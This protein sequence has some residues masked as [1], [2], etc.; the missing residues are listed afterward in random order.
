M[1]RLRVIKELTWNLEDDKWAK[2][3]KPRDLR[4]VMIRL[5]KT[6]SQLCEEEELTMKA[7]AEIA[8]TMM[9]MELATESKLII[10]AARPIRMNRDLK[11]ATEPQNQCCLV[12]IRCAIC[13]YRQSPKDGLTKPI[14]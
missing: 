3:C 10:T 13:F 4:V 9:K 6:A 11:L 8:T 7:V 1:S 5:Y 2:I 14:R 12:S